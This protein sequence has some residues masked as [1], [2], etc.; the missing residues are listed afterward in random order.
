MKLNEL[1]IANIGKIQIEPASWPLL[2]LGILASSS[3]SLVDNGP[4]S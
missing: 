3:S 2:G 4:H 1:G